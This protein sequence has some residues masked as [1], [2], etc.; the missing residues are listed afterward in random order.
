MR[1][2]IA[3]MGAR[4]PHELMRCAEVSFIR[5]C[6]EMAARSSLARTESRWGLYHERADLPGRDD[7]SWLAHLNLRKSPGG[8]MEFLTR[9]VAPY[10]VPVEG[11]EPAPDAEVRVLGEVRGEPVATAG[12]RD[13]PPVGSGR[14][15]SSAVVP[16]AA[17]APA[18]GAPARVVAL[19]AET[20]EQPD[21]AFGYLADPDPVVRRAAL[22]ALTEGVPDGT[23]PALAAALLDPDG[24]V[25]A[26]AASG[27]R[28]LVEVLPPEPGLAAGLEAATESP[29]PLVRAAAVEVS[30]T[31]RLGTAEGFA[32]LLTDADREVRVQVVRALVSVDAVEALASAA[33]DAS[34]EVR[35]AVAAGLGSIGTPAHLATLLS[36]P[37][38]LVRAAALTA[39]ATVGC[40]PPYADAAAEALLDPAWRVREGAASALGA[41]PDASGAAGAAVRALL[42]ALTDPA[43]NVRRAAVRSLLRHL[44]RPGVREALAGLGEDPDA[45]VRAYARRAARGE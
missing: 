31:L 13:V 14:T 29:D 44:D 2:E 18:S 45:D 16:E 7:E 12:R 30:R 41:V 23:G 24:T 25:R 26:A 27:L 38:L 34:R 9:P 6:A 39:L 10:L 42:A 22:G 36:D 5:D 20:A 1:G 19:L 37:D 3:S 40:P 33:A 17:P 21:A 35:V 8:A 15:P 4:T 28:E 43:P 32:A 11:F